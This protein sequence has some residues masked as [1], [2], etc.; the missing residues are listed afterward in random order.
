MERYLIG[1]IGFVGLAVIWLV[2]Q[3]LWKSSF[4][5]Y[6]EDDDV[7]AARGSCSNCNCMGGVCESK[8][9]TH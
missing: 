2:V 7:L 1:I 6:I 9:D 5:N 8:D 3:R 4:E